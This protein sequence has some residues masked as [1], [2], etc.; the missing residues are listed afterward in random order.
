MA[1]RGYRLDPQAGPYQTVWIDTRRGEVE[2]RYYPVADARAAA[3]CVGGVGGGFDSPVRGECYPRLC[4]MLPAHGVAA[5][6]VRF[7]HATDLLEATLDVLAGLHF[8]DEQGIRA[9]ALVGHSFGGAVVIQAAAMS[10]IVRAVATLATQS[11]GTDP[12][13]ELSPRCALLILHGTDDNVLPPHCSRHLYDLA[14][15]PKRLLL[16]PGARHGLDETGNE[17]IDTLRD[18]IVATLGAAVAEVGPAS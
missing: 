16:Y 11:Y 5:L 14:G 4:E 3:L 15:E 7:R 17:V 10:P 12:A 8:L 6:R 18:W 1:L 2:C 9:A 13:A